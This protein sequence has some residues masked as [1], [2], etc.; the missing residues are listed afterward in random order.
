[1]QI[2]IAQGSVP[3]PCRYV[4]ATK[5]VTN[6]PQYT[7]Q[8]RNWKAGDDVAAVDFDFKVPAGARKIGLDELK[9]MKNMGELPSNYIQ[10]R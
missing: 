6:D 4:I 1:M 9:T 8:F 2:W 7:I 5:G 10:G 3:Y